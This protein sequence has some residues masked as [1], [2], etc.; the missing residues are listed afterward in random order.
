[1]NNVA[2]SFCQWLEDNGYGQFGNTLFLGGAP[3]DSPD[4][5]YWVVSGGGSNIGKNASGEKQKN[6]LISIFYRNTDAEDVYN[7]LQALEELLNSKDC[8]ELDNYTVIEVEATL[9]PTDQDLDNE[10]RTTGL[11]QAT[12]TVYQNN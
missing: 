3:L 12:I 5:A 6:Y 1:M 10:E 7:N 11:L 4:E 8:I 9:F 2:R